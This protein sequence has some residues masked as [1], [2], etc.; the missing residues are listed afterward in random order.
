MDC[1]SGHYLGDPSQAPEAV[2][3]P[4]LNTGLF[5]YCHT[6]PSQ[7]KINKFKIRRMSLNCSESYREALEMLVLAL[8]WE[9]S[10]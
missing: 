9:H 6:E 10:A 4:T 5:N 1:E 7:K 8:I 2:L 3:T